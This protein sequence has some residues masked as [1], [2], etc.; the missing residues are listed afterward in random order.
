[1]W[2][3]LPTLAASRSPR[4]QSALE[5]EPVSAWV[6]AGRPAAVVQAF[7]SSLHYRQVALGRT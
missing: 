6:P 4:S 5:S 7:V 2:S 3:L 1:M